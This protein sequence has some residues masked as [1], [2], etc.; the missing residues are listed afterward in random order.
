MF[1]TPKTQIKNGIKFRK[2]NGRDV[3]TL[4]Q[5]CEEHKDT[6]KV[7]WA[8]LHQS[9]KNVAEDKHSNV[10]IIAMELQQT[11]LCPKIRAGVAD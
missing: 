7:P 9:E 3:T 11:L 5:E 10:Q 2:E 4:K 1:N 8:L 6:A